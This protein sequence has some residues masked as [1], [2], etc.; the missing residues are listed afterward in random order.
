[1]YKLFKFPQDLWWILSQSI[2]TLSVIFS[3]IH[4]VLV[5]LLI[6]ISVFVC[7]ALLW[8]K[9]IFY[10][11]YKIKKSYRMLYKSVKICYHKDLNNSDRAV[12]QSD[13][14]E[15]ENRTHLLLKISDSCIESSFNNII[16]LLVDDINEKYYNAK[17]GMTFKRISGLAKGKM[18]IIDVGNGVQ[19][20]ALKHELCHVILDSCFVP[21]SETEQ[22]NIMTRI[23]V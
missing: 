6:S 4:F 17:Y 8:V 16:V 5:A 21:S 15:I 2:A 10:P 3:C 22:H 1:M 14:D 18:I 20:S 23:G 7:F 13:I 9:F 12:I 19:G 11:W